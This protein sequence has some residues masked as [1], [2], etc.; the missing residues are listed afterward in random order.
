MMP[1]SKM[2]PAH[3]TRFGPM[4]SIRLPRAPCWYGHER[5]SFLLNPLQ[6]HQ[7]C[8]SERKGTG[9]IVAAKSS[10]PCSF[11]SSLWLNR[12]IQSSAA[13][14]IQTGCACGRHGWQS[15]IVVLYALC[16][17]IHNQ[18]HRVVV[19]QII[20]PAAVSTLCQGQG[21]VAHLTRSPALYPNE[22]THAQPPQD[23]EALME[24][25]RTLPQFS[26]R[27]KPYPTSGAAWP[28]TAARMSPRMISRLS[29]CSTRRVMSGSD[30]SNASP[31]ATY[32]SASWFAY[33]CCAASA[34]RR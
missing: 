18:I 15:L 31:F 19:G 30:L 1:T 3:L 11:S 8:T 32:P 22:M 5:G 25:P 20:S 9:A 28:L 34:A 33:R 6:G 13:P 10:T 24:G 27:P 17:C 7:D 21:L 16:V 29:S 12:C 14:D 4:D 2:Q 23:L 26:G